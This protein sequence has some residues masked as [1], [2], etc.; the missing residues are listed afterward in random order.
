M[1]IISN[2]D[3]QHNILYLPSE[4]NHVMLTNGKVSHILIIILTTVYLAPNSRGRFL[5]HKPYFHILFCYLKTF[6]LTILSKTQNH[7]DDI[8]LKIYA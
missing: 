4:S 7:K 3:T 6:A 5:P 2:M 8:C 1:V